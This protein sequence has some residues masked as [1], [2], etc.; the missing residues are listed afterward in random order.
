[1][2]IRDKLMHSLICFD[3]AMG[4]MVQRAGLGAGD[5]PELYNMEK[6]EVITE[7]H[8]AYIKA[9]SDVITTNTFGANELKLQNTGYTVEQVITQAVSIARKAAG[10]KKWVALDIGPIGQL[11]EP[12]GTLSFQQAYEIVARQIR[13]GADAG[14]DLVVI[15]TLADIYEAK[16]AVLAVKENCSL[17][18]FCTLTFG[19]EGRTLMG[20]DPLTAVTVL[21][22]LGVD[23]IGAN[24]SVGPKEM[25]SIA[26]E[27]LRYASVPVMIQAN[28]GLPRLEGGKTVFDMNPDDFALS[29]LEMVKRGVRIVG[30]CCGTTPEFIQ[31]IS[32][33]LKGR[34]P[35]KTSPERFAKASSGSKTVIIGAGISVIGERINPS[36]NQSVEKALLEDDTDTIVSESIEQKMAGADILD[37]NVS[38][39]ET[40]EKEMMV[41]VIRQI[42]EMIN[43]PL[44]IDSSSKE[45]LEAGVRI[46][47]GK[48]IINSVT[49]EKSSM[50]AI[51][52]IVKKYGAC[53]VGLTMDEN[54]IPDCAE[55]RVN[56]ARRIVETAQSFGIPREDILIDCLVLT[57]ATQQ[58]KVM[59]TLEAVTR[60]KKELGVNTVLGISNVSYGLPGRGILNRT[61]LAMALA[62]GL[63]A[64]I[65]NPMADDM[66]ETIRA[67]EVF[68]NSD[69]NAQ[70]FIKKY[71]RKRG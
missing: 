19:R 6:P 40:D 3:G 50:E 20:T 14:A 60:V 42:Q 49:G 11:M 10:D 13:A 59:E 27:F 28:A 1:M 51:F 46:Y 67:Y 8:K 26:D 45:V 38:S 70:E 12:S 47:N 54:G 53:V 63:D 2:E 36:G 68:S 65:M 22:G 56:I 32:R 66:M 34:E 61:Y 15:E 21:E 64:P 31:S 39:P 18:V 16:A 58:Q 33:N 35:V 62:A 55:D 25:V 30:G 37:V 29:V 5:L 57:A 24:C 17:P 69:T 9:G 7:I 41:R 4:T 23:A 44:Q 71:G 43:L 52:P 48:P